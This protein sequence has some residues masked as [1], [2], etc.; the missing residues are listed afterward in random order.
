MGR[1]WVLPGS[2]VLGF[3]DSPWEDLPSLRNEWEDGMGVGDAKVEEA[4]GGKGMGN[5][6]VMKM[7]KDSLLK[8]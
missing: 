3:A 1:A 5:G 7:R 8:K 2:N 6:F 4:G